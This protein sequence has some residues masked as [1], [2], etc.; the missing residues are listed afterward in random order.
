MLRRDPNADKNLAPAVLLLSLLTAASVLVSCDTRPL[1]YKPILADGKADQYAPEFVRSLT[2]ISNWADGTPMTTP[3]R[4]FPSPD[5]ATSPNG[6]F[7]VTQVRLRDYHHKIEI[8]DLTKGSAETIVVL[9]EGAPESGRGHGIAWSSD[10]KAVFIY[11]SA[12]PVGYDRNTDM[13]LIYLVEQKTL[14]SVDIRPLL[15]NNTH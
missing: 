6:L 12:Q 10:S 2:V 1:T 13:A 8:A 9:R 3:A 7:V 4:Y 11:G 14:H 5:R 15:N